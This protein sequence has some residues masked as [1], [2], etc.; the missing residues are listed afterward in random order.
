MKPALLFVLGLAV[1]LA[2]VVVGRASMPDPAP[3]LRVQTVEVDSPEL[4]ELVQELALEAGGMGNRLSGRRE[5]EPQVV[6]RSRDVIP[7][8][9][10]CQLTWQIDGDQRLAISP[11]LEESADSSG[12]PLYRAQLLDGIDVTRC[13]DGLS[14]TPDGQVVCDVPRLGHLSARGAGGVWGSEPWAFAGLE[15]V[16]FYRSSWAV[17]AG[18][19]VAGE[20][21]GVELGA[22]WRFWGL[23]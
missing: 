6:Y 3:Q 21:S 17:R 2:G 11:L 12:A 23:W 4:L 14:A 13:D 8:P 5:L 18:Y 20:L 9:P 16:P 10:A 7:A 22:E 19:R 15:W 1:L